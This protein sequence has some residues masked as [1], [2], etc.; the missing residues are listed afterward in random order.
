MGVSTVLVWCVCVEYTSIDMVNTDKRCAV[1]WVLTAYCACSVCCSHTHGITASG[2]RVRQ[3]YAACNWLPYHT[4]L[5]ITK[6]NGDTRVVKVMDR[7]SQS[8]FGSR[9]KPKRRL[10]IYTPGHIQALMFGKQSAQIRILRYGKQ[11]VRR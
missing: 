11:W 1:N 5:L 10:D 2:H 4:L 3:G 8:H 7:G 9:M 6:P